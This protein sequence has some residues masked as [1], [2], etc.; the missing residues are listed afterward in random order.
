MT[1]AN[2]GVSDD[3]CERK[4]ARAIPRARHT[5]GAAAARAALRGTLGPRIH[6]RVARGRRRQANKATWADA[7]GRWRG[8]CGRYILRGVDAID[9]RFALTIPRPDL[10]SRFNVAPGQLLPVIVEEDGERRVALMRWGLVPPW[11]KDGKG[12][13]NARSETAAEKPSFREPL[14]RRRCLV[15]ADGYYEWQA[16]PRGKTPYAIRFADGSLFAM[17]GIWSQRRGAEGAPEETFAILT[18]A[19]NAL[20]APIHD[21][22]PVILRQRD[23]GAWLTAD[24]DAALQPLL[25]PYDPAVMTAFPVFRRVNTVRNDDCEL[26]HPT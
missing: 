1:Y 15:P 9:E 2:A 7:F 22:M 21:R 20:T 25:I 24:D 17:A 8:L 26:V 23:E 6:Q 14:A 16:G 10:A 4:T 19:A 5:A 11:S 13:I 18:T 12:F 3:A